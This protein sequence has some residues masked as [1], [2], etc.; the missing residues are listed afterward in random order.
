MFGWRS[1]L[2]FLVPPGNP[3]LEPEMMA[4]VPKGVSLHFSRLAAS[5]VTGSLSGQEERNREQ[6]AGIDGTISLLSLVRPNVI[7]LAHTSTSYTLGISGEAE[8]TR[9]IEA[10]Y[11]T[12]FITAFGSVLAAFAH[13]G[14]TRVALA[15]P[16]SAETT[17]QGKVLLEQHGLQV[18]N[19]GNLAGVTNIY[20]ETPERAYSIGRQV[21]RP[22][23]QAV[24]ISGVGMPT[25]AMI[26]AL[27]S[28][29][30]KPVVS[31]SSAMMWNALRVTGVRADI[32]G[33]GKLL[34]NSW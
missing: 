19:H 12:P 10:K 17:L 34:R 9:T 1:R 24:F 2:G 7:V 27:E 32:D 25:I 4:L 20:D 26:D 22:E 3:T 23:A 31:A 14:V 11:K 18:V 33:A 21:D 16:Y 13:L 6:I 30:G 5:G 15:T 29:L 8:L 28:D